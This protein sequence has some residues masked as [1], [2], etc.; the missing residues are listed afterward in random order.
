MIARPR[1]PP[2]RRVAKPISIRPRKY[3]KNDR[4]GFMQEQRAM[5]QP[6]PWTEVGLA[7]LS[8]LQQPRLPSLARR[9]DRLAYDVWP[10]IDVLQANLAGRDG[11][12]V[13]SAAD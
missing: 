6:V 10:V 2:S 11:D 9:V 1:T 8:R 4:F 5:S 12:L 7:A 13:N 3:A